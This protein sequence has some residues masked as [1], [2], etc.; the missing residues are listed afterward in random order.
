VRFLAVGAGM[1]DLCRRLPR[2]GP[3]HFV[4]HRLEELDA[5]RLGGIVIN[6]GGVDVGDLLVKTPL[7]S[8]DS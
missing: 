8:A 6:A 3:V 4:L 1:D 2:D 7:G 5:G